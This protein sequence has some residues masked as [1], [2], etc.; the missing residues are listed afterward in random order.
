MAEPSQRAAVLSG[1]SPSSSVTITEVPIPEIGPLDVL[2]RLSATGLCH[3]DLVLAQGHFGPCASILG[4]EGVGRVV[5]VGSVVL[6]HKPVAIG[7]RVGIGWLNSVCGECDICYTNSEQR[8]CLKQKNYGRHV[9]GT[10]AEYVVVPREY[11]IKL[12]EGPA[13][14]QLAPIL[15]GGVTAYKALKICGARA[16]QWIALMGA[17]GGLGGLGIQYAKAMGL[18]VVAVDGG[19]EK[20]TFALSLGADAFV[21][22][23]QTPDTVGAIRAA[24]EGKGVMAAL[25]L[26]GS[27]KAYQDALAALAPFGTL[28][29]VGIPPPTQ[30]LQFHPLMLIDLGIRIIGS[31][32]GSRVDLLEAVR[33]V[34]EGLVKPTVCLKELEDLP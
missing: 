8:R 9:D 14:E 19:R 2:V 34:E 27:G 12:P 18:K 10:F 15:C 26:A 1:Q 7:Q 31:L 25:V 6:A 20:E 16:G 13:D 32:V 11:L 33:F 30:T 21:D 24:S 28:V 4:H 22:F 5:E 17:G 3:T 29:A 23:M